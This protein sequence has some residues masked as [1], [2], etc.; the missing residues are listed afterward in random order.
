MPALLISTS[1]PPRRAT[2]SRTMRSMSARRDMS[3]GR[4]INPGISCAIAS[5]ALVSMSQTNTLA[6]VAANARANSPPMPAA[7]AVIKTRCGIVPP[8]PVASSSLRL[9]ESKRSKRSRTL[10]ILA[11]ATTFQPWPL[12]NPLASPTGSSRK[13]RALA[14][15]RRCA[16]LKD[17]GAST[18]PTACRTLH[19]RQKVSAATMSHHLKELAAAG[20]IEIVRDGKFANL[21]LQRGVL[22]AYLG[23]LAKI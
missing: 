19:K 21:V 23:R 22:R 1:S 13:S 4:A 5:S 10:D 17:I 3:Q 8:S 16:M 20:L 11:P 15:P 9:H 18:V 6:P 2:A 12:P 7:P 14:E